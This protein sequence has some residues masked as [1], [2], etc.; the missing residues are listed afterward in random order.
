MPT[1]II[2]YSMAVRLTNTVKTAVM[3]TAALVTTPALLL[4]PPTM[5]SLELAPSAHRSLIRLRMKMW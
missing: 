1:P 3:I 2:L 5:E 4:M